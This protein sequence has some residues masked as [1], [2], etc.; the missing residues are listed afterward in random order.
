MESGGEAGLSREPS[1]EAP[2]QK[3]GTHAKGWVVHPPL[4]PSL[5]GGMLGKGGQDEIEQ[6]ERE[7]SSC[8]GIYLSSRSRWTR[9]S[10]LNTIHHLGQSQVWRHI[11]RP[12]W[13]FGPASR[14]HW[15]VGVVTVAMDAPGEAEVNGLYSFPPA[16]LDLHCPLLAKTII[17]Y[18]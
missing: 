4:F 11:V 1:G 2:G 15:G 5:K 12:I 3:R 17:S 10:D 6:T 8:S 13:V 18:R 16:S 9:S 7:S 14:G